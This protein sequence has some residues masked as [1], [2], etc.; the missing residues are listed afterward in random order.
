MQRMDPEAAAD[1][2]GPARVQGAAPL[3]FGIPETQPG[4]GFEV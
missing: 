1:A 2:V 4:R 3:Q